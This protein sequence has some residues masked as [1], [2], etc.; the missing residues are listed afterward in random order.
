M[1][2]FL[3]YED[4][5]ARVAQ[6]AS[7]ERA[8]SVARFLTSPSE[9]ERIQGLLEAF[10]EGEQGYPGLVYVYDLAQAKPFFEQPDLI[11]DRRLRHPQLGRG[12][13][14]VLVPRGGLEHSD[15]RQRR[16]VAHAGD[17]K[18]GLSTASTVS[19]ARPAPCA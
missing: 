2:P 7:L 8:E 15:R 6:A 19:L 12:G 18:P 10:D 17:H 9:R 4:Y 11:T 16:Q 3:T 5:L 13:G 1:I 14:E